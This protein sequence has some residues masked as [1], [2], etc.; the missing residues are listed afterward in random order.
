ME[1]EA[2][3][4]TLLEC[5]ILNAFIRIMSEQAPK[6]NREHAGKSQQNEFPTVPWDEIYRAM[7]QLLSL[8]VLGTHYNRIKHTRPLHHP[9]NQGQQCSTP[10][11]IKSQSPYESKAFVCKRRRKAKSFLRV[12]A[13]DS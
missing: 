12:T 3:G 4:K 13:K 11:G 9:L 1:H 2:K 7:K 8:L 5:H 6:N 10:Q